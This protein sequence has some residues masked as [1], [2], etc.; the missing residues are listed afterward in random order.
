[1]Y[2]VDAHEYAVDTDSDYAPDYPQSGVS[3]TAK[4]RKTRKLFYISGFLIYFVN[5]QGGNRQY[6][7]LKNCVTRDQR[8]RSR[9]SL[10]ITSTA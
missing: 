7:P 8:K 1:M 2:T 6:R 10:P 5:L 4:G 3:P 9:A